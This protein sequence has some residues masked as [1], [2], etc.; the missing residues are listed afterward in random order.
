MDMNLCC[1]AASIKRLSSARLSLTLPV[2]L[3]HKSVFFTVLILA[4]SQQEILTFPWI[5]DCFPQ[6]TR[7]RFALDLFFS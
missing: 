6:A 7:G 2:T 5:A 4:F 1:R 3:S